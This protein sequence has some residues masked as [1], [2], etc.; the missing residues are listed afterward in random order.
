MSEQTQ[1][2]TFRKLCENHDLTYDYSDDNSVYRQGD[3]QYKEIV[4]FAKVIPRDE[5][6]R[7]WNEVVMKKTR[8]PADYMWSI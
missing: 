3:A 7:I 2:D 4:Q 1:L 6:V 8:C 5:A